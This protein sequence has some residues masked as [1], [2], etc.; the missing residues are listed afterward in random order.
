MFTRIG[1]FLLTNLLVIVTINIVLAIFG[2]KPYLTA[3]GIDYQS[4]LVFCAV[5]GMGGAVISLLL[6]KWMAKRA[7]HLQIIDATTTGT[8]ERSLY[9]TVK[10]LAER[11]GLPTTPEVGIYNAA[12]MNA[13]A[14]GPS[15]RHALVAVSSGLL[16]SMNEAQVEAVLGHE[17]SHIKNGDMVTLT[18]IQGVVNAFAL[19]LSRILAYAVSIALSRNSNREQSGPGF[20]YFIFSI[21]F[22]ILFTTLGSLVV[23]AFSRWR[24]YRAD[25]GGARL[26]GK[27]NMIS[28]LSRLAQPAVLNTQTET[29]RQPAMDIMKISH[30]GRWLGLF[31]THPPMAARIAR[32]AALM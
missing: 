30:P 5:W 26:A 29:T 7:M 8:S 18:L 11:A 17:I 23:A 16:R 3:H 20:S 15:A 14:T 2:L 12:E 10:R 27:Q 22:D 25:A 31:A 32:L 13:F 9:M 6:S 21:V 1:L 19:F 4:L 28:A 24:E